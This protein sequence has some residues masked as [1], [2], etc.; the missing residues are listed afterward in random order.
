METEDFSPQARQGYGSFRQS[1]PQSDSIVLLL[2]R[3][4]MNILPIGSDG[5]HYVLL[6]CNH[7]QRN[8]LI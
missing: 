8:D 4:L 5:A 2:L 3:D 1:N 7:Q 6:P